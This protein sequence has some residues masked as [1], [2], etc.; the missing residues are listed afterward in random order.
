MGGMGFEAFLLVLR[1]CTIR[2]KWL[3]TCTIQ[4]SKEQ[5]FESI[6]S[7]GFFH[8]IEAKKPLKCARF[9]SFRVFTV[10]LLTVEPFDNIVL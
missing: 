10:D 7:F 8:K 3:C 5:P 2:G 9:V 4:K 6:R 1:K